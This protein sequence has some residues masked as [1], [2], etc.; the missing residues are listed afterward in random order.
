MRDN[1]RLFPSAPVNIACSNTTGVCWVVSQGSDFVVRMSVSGGTPT[2]NAPTMAGPFAVSPV[3]RIPTIDAA[4]PLKS[5]RN[6]RGIALNTDGTRGY[7]V[8]PTTRDVVVADLVGNTVLQHVRSSELPSDPAQLSIL[9]G[10]IDFFTSRPPGPIAAGCWSATDGG[11]DTVT[12]SFEAGPRQ[13]IALDGTFSHLDPEDQRTLNWS[14]VRDENQDFELNTRGV[15]GG[16]GFISVDTD[17]NAD[18]LMPDSDP[19]GRNFG[20]ASSGRVQQQEDITAYIQLAIRS[21]LAPPAT[22]DA[23]R[24]RTLFAGGEGGA[25]C[26]PA[27]GGGP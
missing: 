6:P 5:G 24:G 16:R 2:I 19:N 21:P 3:V 23:A 12:W 4:D 8:C 18:G 14:P 10:K 22:G 1:E 27:S 15:F 11:T 7:V 25:N 20:P 13:T 9:R 26:S 17:L